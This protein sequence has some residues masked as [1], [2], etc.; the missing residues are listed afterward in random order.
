M[1]EVFAGNNALGDLVLGCAEGGAILQPVDA[2]DNRPD[3]SGPDA[4]YVRQLAVISGELLNPDGLHV[5]YLNGGA[6]KLLRSGDANLD[7]VVNVGDL[8]VLAAHWGVSTRLWGEGDFNGNGTVDVAD[9]GTLAGSWGATPVGQAQSVPEPASAALLAMMAAGVGWMRRGRSLRRGQ[10]AAVV[11]LAATLSLCPLAAMA[12]EHQWQGAGTG[13]NTATDVTDPT[14]WWAWGQNWAEPALPSS[15]DA[16]L[17]NFTNA[18]Y[19]RG[20]GTIAS[21]SVS[22]TGGTMVLDGAAVMSVSQQTYLGSSGTAWMVQTDGESLHNDLYLGGTL[23]ATGCYQISGGLLS[24]FSLWS[25]KGGMGQVTQSGNSLVDVGTLYIGYGTNS[26]GNYTLTSGSL[27]SVALT[28][29]SRGSFILNGGTHKVTNS[30][31]AGAGSY[32]ITGGLLQVYMACNGG[33]FLNTG[34]THTVSREFAPSGYRMTDGLLTVGGTTYTEKARVQQ[35]GGTANYASMIYVGSNYAGEYLLSGGVMTAP[36]VYLSDAPGTLFSQTGGSARIDT[37]YQSAPSTWRFGGGT[38]RTSSVDARGAVDFAGGFGAISSP[39]GSTLDFSTATLTGGQNTSMDLG[40]NCLAIFP[41]GIVPETFFAHYSNLGI[42]HALGQ[43]LTI[44]AG[45]TLDISSTINESVWVY[46]TLLDGPSNRLLLRRGLHVYDGGSATL[47]SGSLR[48]IDQESGLDNGVITADSVTVNGRFEQTAGS[49]TASG[50]W[51]GTE[52]YMP[53]TFVI[54]GGRVTTPYLY[55]GSSADGSVSQSGGSVLISQNLSVP[56]SS[57]GGRGSYRMTNGYLRSSSVFLGG[58]YAG[59]FAQD[60]GTQE[61]T[62]VTI[63]M[64]GLMTVGGGS[65]KATRIRNNAGTFR[66]AGGSTILSGT[67]SLGPTNW[68][69]GSTNGPAECSGGYL[70]A[71]TLDVA[72]GTLTQTGGTAKGGQLILRGP[73][74]AYRLG[75]GLLD[76][77]LMDL[78]ASSQFEITDASARTR[79]R[80]MTL[81]VGSGFAAVPGSRLDFTYENAG[82]SIAATDDSIL[83]LPPDNPL[84]GLNSTTFAFSSPGVA[85]AEASCRDVGLDPSGWDAWLHLAGLI[86]G[87]GT[88]TSGLLIVDYAD[89]LL[90]YAAQALYVDNLEFLAGGYIEDA[91]LNLYYRNGGSPKRFIRGDATL[92]GMVNVGDLGVL[93][94]NWGAAGASWSRGDFNGDR[95]VNVGDLAILASHWGGVTPN[96]PTSV[97]EPTS[98]LLLAGV[99]TAAMSLRRRHPKAPSRLE[100]TTMM[101]L[102]AGLVLL[103]AIAGPAA[104][105]TVYDWN[106]L[107]TIDGERVYGSDLNNLGQVCGYYYDRPASAYRVTLWT[108][109][110]TDGVPTNP[111]VRVLNTSGRATAEA[112][113]DDGLIVGSW[114]SQAFVYRNGTMTKLGTFGYSSSSA[115]DVNN[116]GQVLVSAYDGSW[117]CYIK[118]WQDGQPVVGVVSGASDRTWATCINE[119]GVVAG[120]S[121]FEACIWGVGTFSELTAV[122]D[123]NDRGMAVGSGPK[124]FLWRDRDSDSRLDWGETEY[125]LPMEASQS[126]ANAINNA[127]QVVGYYSINSQY[128]AFIYDGWDPKPLQDLMAPGCPYALTIPEDIN[129]LGQIL[130]EA[131]DLDGRTRY[132]VLT[133]RETALPEP[134]TLALVALGAWA[135]P[136]RR[137]RV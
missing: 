128:T 133:P 72:R 123:M 87:G 33:T 116:N 85:T 7:G 25:G 94:G 95:I 79:L 84:T 126:S 64:A 122:N 2:R 1:A 12:D 69:D 127:G 9:L 34:G 11:L 23:G 42:T 136:R 108:P 110:G 18:G 13:G 106:C 134:A 109:G 27:K 117:G 132:V 88:G 10:G 5:Y 44:P 71:P 53:G 105:A 89:N 115:R 28:M 135:S 57:W 100:R 58:S 56:Q 137:R 93:A 97:P 118:I 119:S 78:R 68:S 83:P 60:G 59:T 45:R 35:E 19:L 81:A 76:T 124:A 70:Y 21:L 102:L 40:A 98:A 92:D 120:R 99:A 113:N 22:G 16:V 36:K 51:L 54:S 114:D 103:G 41:A 90:D 32:Q 50:M 82:L 63:E 121:N 86:V 38:L 46:G 17:V 104:A 77:P 43:T 73:G 39:D 37:I 24:T 67:L 101:K 80:R 96:P 111:Q 47:G 31:N 91:P 52:Y 107:G 130:C 14:T 74:T 48:V 4:V 112:I 6:P 3:V 62:E 30:F 65:F 66:Q 8:G 15:E 131:K 61:T 49:M 129:D 75:A 125:L 20:G 55:V 29:G 26:T